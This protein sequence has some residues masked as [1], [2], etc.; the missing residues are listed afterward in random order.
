MTREDLRTYGAEIRR[1]YHG[2]VDALLNP[3]LPQLQN[4]DGDP[5]E[6]TSMT[7]TLTMPVGEAFERPLATIRGE[8]RVDGHPDCFATHS[9]DCADN[10]IASCSDR[11][12][13]GAIT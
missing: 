6:L 4:T 1:F 3:A 7:Y 11:R 8:A 5:L 9:P 13:T 10:R 12:L 2:I